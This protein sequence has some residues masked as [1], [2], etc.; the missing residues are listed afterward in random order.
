MLFH[1]TSSQHA[2][3]HATFRLYIVF[4]PEAHFEKLE[5]ALA[6]IREALQKVEE[7]KP[8]EATALMLASDSPDLQLQPGKV[9]LAYA[10]RA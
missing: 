4:F 3:L 6:L 2:K 7:E 9:L 8:V 1:G 5:N 10:A